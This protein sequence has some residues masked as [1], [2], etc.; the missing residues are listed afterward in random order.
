VKHAAAQYG[1]FG[2]RVNCILPDLHITDLAMP[3]DKASRKERLRF[4]DE[5]ALI[6]APLRR[7]EMEPVPHE[8]TRAPMPTRGAST[9]LA[10][11]P[12]A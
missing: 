3:K 11:T 6:T 10:R 4:L 1:E 12:S 8:R 5:M 9:S 2:I 7:V